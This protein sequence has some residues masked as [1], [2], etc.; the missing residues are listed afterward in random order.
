MD[1]S[2]T[3]VSGH[4]DTNVLKST[5]VDKNPNPLLSSSSIPKQS[6]QKTLDALF[7]ALF[8]KTQSEAHILNSLR[9]IDISLNLKATMLDIQSIMNAIKQEALLSKT[10][11]NLDKF[12]VDIK[13]LDAQ[14][15][16]K[17]IEKSG[18]FFESKL[19]QNSKE[20]LQNPAI[21]ES[22]LGD[23]KASLLQI[24][25]HL[26]TQNPI[27]PLDLLAK[28]DKVLMSIHYYQLMALCSHTTILYLPFSWEGLQGGN[29]SIK[30]LKEK[31]FFCEIHLTLKEFGDIDVFAML[32]D[33]V[34]TSIS[35][36]TEN[37]NFLKL[38]NEYSDVLREAIQN[39]GL[40]V[41]S[42]YMYDAR[43]D[44]SIK[45]EIQSMVTSL[46]TGE[47]INLHA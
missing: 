26:K 11:I 37:K 19:A 41:S 22:I 16:Q 29:I 5:T 20:N 7:E 44:H 12:F 39:A 10:V 36:F 34:Y 38:L 46:Q 35:F 15:L 18:L 47:G 23:I 1:I 24:K 43:K 45:Q 4:H 21:K 27:P 6:I 2:K 9:Q 30:K 28:V 33:D 3:N 31:R 8:S 40:I 17:Q 13:T 42:L 25:E 32:F 14:G